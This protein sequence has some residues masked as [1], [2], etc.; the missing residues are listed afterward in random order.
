MTKFHSVRAHVRRSPSKPTRPAKFYEMTAKLAKEC[1]Y[2]FRVKAV[3]RLVW[4][5]G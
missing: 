1:G 2:K 3:S 4:R 5:V